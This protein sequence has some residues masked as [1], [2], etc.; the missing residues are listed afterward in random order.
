[1]FNTHKPLENDLPTSSQLLRSTIIALFVAGALLVCIVIPAEY[2]TDPTGVGELL[3]LKKM[4]EIKANL[5]KESQNENQKFD[6]YVSTNEEMRKRF[7][8][9]KVN[10]DVMEFVIAPDD[11]IEVKLEMEKGSS[12]KYKWNTNSGGLNYNLHGDGYKGS[13]KSTTYKKGRMTTSDNGEFK[14]EFDGYHGWFWRNRNSEIVTVILETDG[15]YIQIKR[16]E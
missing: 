3:G 13:Q 8:N 7:Q 5:E 15:E 16:M 9:T 6:E 2:G 11:A 10:K 12:V 1:M 4:G 14:A